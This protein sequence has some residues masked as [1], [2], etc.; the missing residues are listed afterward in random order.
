[1]FVDGAIGGRTCILSAEAE[2]PDVN[3]IRVI[4][5]RD[6]SESV[7]RIH[8]D[9]NRV[10]IHANGDAAIESA[11]DAIQLAQESNYRPEV[12]HRIE[13][14]SVITD[15]ILERLQSLRIIVVPFSGYPAYYG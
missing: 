12:R 11:L 3:G 5:D 6:L 10:A 8:N 4:S 2:R 1:A 13:H 15:K 9:G 14:C 7:R